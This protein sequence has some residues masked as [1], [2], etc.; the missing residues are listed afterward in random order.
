MSPH[1]GDHERPDSRRGPR[2]LRQG[3]RSWS[4]PARCSARS[5]TPPSRPAERRPGSEP[6]GRHRRPARPLHRSGSSRAPCRSPAPAPAPPAS[7]RP[8]R[9]PIPTPTRADEPFRAEGRRAPLPRACRCRR[10]AEAVGHAG[11]C[12]FH[13][14]PGAALHRA[15]RRPGRTPGLGDALI[16]FAVKAN[17]NLVGAARPWRGWARA[18]TRSPRARS[19]GRWRPASRPS[20]SSS[21]ASARPR[22]NWPSPSRSAS[23]EINVESEPELD[24]LIAGRRR[25]RG[26]APTIAIRVNPDVGAGGH[27]KI[28]TGKADNKF[29]VSFDEA[30]RLYARAANTPACQA[31]RAGL[32]HRQPDHRPGPA[33]GGLRQDARPGRAPARRGPAASTRL[34]LGGGLGVPYFDMPDPAVARRLCGHGRARAGRAGG[35]SSPS[36][37]AG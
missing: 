32:P 26:P 24:R 33:G 3:G 5:A 12:L 2:R 15:A 22:P 30:E 16:A 4:V 19:G 35:R 21:P 13:R 7:R 36:S 20:G 10:I 18:P 8:A 11:L 14:H 34:D 9:C 6:P 37:P 1:S 17:S 31:R 25:R 27:A 23:R 29:G 28:T